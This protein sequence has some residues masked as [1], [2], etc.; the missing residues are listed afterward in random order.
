MIITEIAGNLADLSPDDRSRL[1]V[2]RVFF[3]NE[4]RLKR[5]QRVTSDAGEEVALRLGSEVRELHDGDVLRLDGDRAIVA[6][7]SPTDVLAIAP[8][9]VREALVIA[10]TLGNRHLQAQFFDAGSEFG[11]DV[12]VVRYDHTVEHYLDHVG[13]DYQRVEHVMPEAF[14]HAEH[15][16]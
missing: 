16:H 6:A 1:E 8:R 2:D 3:D 12:M 11:R 9:S 10:H 5:V 7:I 14:R 15:S 13:A 4:S